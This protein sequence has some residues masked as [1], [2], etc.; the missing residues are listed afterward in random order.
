MPDDNW[1]VR[2]KGRML[3]PFPF[4]KL[5]TLRDRSMLSRFDDVSKDGKTWIVASQI[6]ALFEELTDQLLQGDQPAQKMIDQDEN[7]FNKAIETNFDRD[8]PTRSVHW[9]Y[10]KDGVHVGP[11]SFSELQVLAAR[12]ELVDQSLVWNENL[13]SWIHASTLPGIVFPRTVKNSIVPN[14]APLPFQI[15]YIDR[16]VKNGEDKI[17]GNGSRST[18][19]L[20]GFAVSGFILGILAMILC[21]SIY[22]IIVGTKTKFLAFNYYVMIFALPVITIVSIICGILSTIF[23]SIALS[24]V[25]RHGKTL[26]GKD[27]AICGLVLGISVL[28]FMLFLCWLPGY[29]E[30]MIEK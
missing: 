14:T 2:S 5:E 13:P 21:V 23:S 10:V 3:G 12:G 26:K 9:Y 28:C 24:A 11:I 18:P 22:S 30:S 1:Y 15:E 4:S 6:P 8:D 7:L 17:S 19:R 20:S 16:S 29:L 27:M 25:E